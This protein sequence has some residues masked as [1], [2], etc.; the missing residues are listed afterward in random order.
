MISVVPID[1]V[2]VVK[3]KDLWYD[4]TTKKF[5]GSGGSKRVEKK[6]IGCHETERIDWSDDDGQT[7]H[8]DGVQFTP[9]AKEHGITLKC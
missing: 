4:H 8:D 6:E 3:F 9:K 1:T 5:Y 2:E 7:W